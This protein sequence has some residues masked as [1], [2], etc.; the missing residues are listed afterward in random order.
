M[1]EKLVE[2]QDANKRKE[3]KKKGMLV[4]ISKQVE[5]LPTKNKAIREQEVKHL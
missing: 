4:K 2:I 1:K 5:K 3:E